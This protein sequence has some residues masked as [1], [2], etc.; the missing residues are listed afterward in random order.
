MPDELRDA[1]REQLNQFLLK[2]RHSLIRS[3]EFYIVQ[4]KIDGKQ[5]LRVTIIN[6]LTTV[7]HLDGLLDAIRRTGQAILNTD[8]K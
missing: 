2:L 4:T 6:P 1:S 5:A 8:P 3:G 7:D